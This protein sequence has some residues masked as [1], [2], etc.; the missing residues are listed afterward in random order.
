MQTANSEECDDA[1]E[2]N[3]DSCTNACKNAVCGDGFVF[4]GCVAWAP[5]WLGSLLSQVIA[6]PAP[7]EQCDQGV[8]N[9]DPTVANKAY[10]DVTPEDYS[11][12]L[13]S[14][15]LAVS[16]KIARCSN[17][18]D[19]DEDTFADGADPG[20]L[21]GD[22][23]IGSQHGPTLIGY[24]HEENPCFVGTDPGDV[25]DPDAESS[26]ASSIASL[27]ALNAD[28]GADLLAAAIGD[29]CVKDPSALVNSVRIRRAVDGGYGCPAGSR[30]SLLGTQFQCRPLKPLGE[31]CQY[32]SDCM[33]AYSGTLLAG[34][35]TGV[36]LTN[37]EREA[38]GYPRVYCLVTSVGG[39]AG[40]F[41]NCCIPN[42]PDHPCGVR[43]DPS[44]PTGL[45]PLCKNAPG[46]SG[47]FPLP[48]LPPG[49]SSTG[50][51]LS[52]SSESASNESSE[53]TASN[54]SSSSGSADTSSHQSSFSAESESSSSSF[55]SASSSSSSSPS[56]SSSISSSPSSSSSSS[57]SP[58]SS[59]SSSPSSS[60][61]YSS[62]LAF[63]S[64]ASA[65]SSDAP[66]AVDSSSVPGTGNQGGP[67]AFCGDRVVSPG[68]QC[69][70]PN[71]ATCNGSCRQ[72]VGGTTGTGLSSSS[73]NTGLSSTGRQSS[74][75]SR[76]NACT[77]LE[78]FEVGDLYCISFG[79]LCETMGES[80]CIRC[81]LINEAPRRS[82]SSSVTTN[83]VDSNECY[84]NECSLGGDEYCNGLDQTCEQTAGF[85]CVRC[86]TAS[87]RTSSR[88][89]S[90]S[91]TSN[92]CSNDADCPAGYIC[93][94]GIC[95]FSSSKS[96]Q[97]SR[98][99]DNSQCPT[100][101]CHNGS[102]IS[103]S[104]NRQC[105][106]NFCVNGF[107][108]PCSVD[109]Q[110]ATGLCV[111]GVCRACTNNTQ[112][113]T[114]L[115]VSGTCGVCS[116]NSQC[117]SALCRDGICI[118]CTSDLDCPLPTSC[119]NGSCQRQIRLLPNFCGNGRLNSGES[120]DEGAKNTMTPNATCRTDC[121]AGR[122]GDR[123]L[124]TPLEICDDG[125][126]ANGDGCSSVCQTER[127]APGTLPGQVIDIPFDPNTN[128]SSSVG[129]G[130]RN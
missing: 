6:C 54:G 76:G 52:S 36:Y 67:T 3:A 119:H 109:A 81:M 56:P 98:C 95:T 17:S 31:V 79:Q 23:S 110:C 117:A 39:A 26:D 8:N 123:V 2:S 108:L 115:C 69:E 84:G 55:S 13:K 116:S 82:S 127:A 103:C 19:D 7:A 29:A 74:Q 70:P 71:T 4:E 64:S 50:F 130:N 61:S 66:V 11:E 126:T 129:S 94:N 47:G 102:C 86:I 30:C 85:P 51:D 1:N 9:V 104:E 43:S 91:S 5:R 53:S 41:G 118:S 35:T 44:P 100:G 77:G 124:D 96:S 22:C 128:Q 80:P 62:L 92:G 57:P 112:C 34:Y 24:N 72:I 60:S 78:C 58:F 73:S 121:T 68:E 21:E 40:T 27:T 38:L 65:A 101:L 111:T 33:D 63:N 93:R 32:T 107:C 25:A 18:L 99:A 113:G 122:C 28:L 45:P 59:I 87:S 10:A 37:D 14:N 12:L 97:S 83:T 16:C 42:H 105:G 125:N 49:S 75:N 20:C 46:F 48:P 88:S 89:S 106:S 120:C 90:S 15:C 114:N